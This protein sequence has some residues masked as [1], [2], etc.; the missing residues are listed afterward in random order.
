MN[1]YV[2]S[3]SDGSGIIGVFKTKQA[4][5]REALQMKGFLSVIEE[6]E[7]QE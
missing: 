2:L 3:F 6:C 4:A 1:V 5:E 7:V